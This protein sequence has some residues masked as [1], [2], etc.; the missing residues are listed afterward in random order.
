MEL[1]IGETIKRLRRERDLTQEEVATHLG[2]SFQSISKW[3]RGDGYP[4]IT[5]L[6]ALANYFGI[7]VDELL[8]T[9][10]LEKRRQYDEINQTWAE[11]NRQ[12]R[13]RENVALMRRSL[14]RFP[15]DA[16]LLVQL[17][18]SLEKLDGTD[19]EKRR[20]LL[21]SIAVQ[22]Q[23]LRYGEDS[24]VRGATMYNICH[25]YWKA[26]ERDKALAQAQKLPNLY[27]ARENALVYFLEGEEK[28]QVAREAITP[29]AWAIVHHLSALAEP[30]DDPRYQQRA[31]SILKILWECDRENEFIKKTL[32]E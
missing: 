2:V 11:N 13:N 12:K 9:S 17:S 26:G 25:A 1:L 22:E 30:E 16:L 6:P 15:N 18:T 24:E 3:E 4:D 8:G 19:E 31:L 29:L 23:I 21:E 32:E 20:H 28:R 7:S 5:M 14:K 27:K 10:E